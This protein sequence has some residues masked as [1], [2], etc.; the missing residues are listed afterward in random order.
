[1]LQINYIMLVSL[2]RSPSN[3]LE[4]GTIPLA[5]SHSEKRFAKVVFLDL[6]NRVFPYCN[7]NP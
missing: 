2:Y 3:T 7:E 5:L 1:M 4:N 6:P